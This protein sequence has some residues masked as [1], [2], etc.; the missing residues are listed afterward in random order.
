MFTGVPGTVLIPDWQL[1]LLG[2]TLLLA[3]FEEKLEWFERLITAP[4][5]VYATAIAVL[6]L[7][8]E[9]IG[10]TDVTIPFVYFQF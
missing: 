2:I 4:A 8:L 10:V 9:L 5:W 7:C 3:I 6:L 1:W